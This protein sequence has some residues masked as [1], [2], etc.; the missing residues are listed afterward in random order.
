[1]FWVKPHSDIP[2]RHSGKVTEP[3]E[4]S[5]LFLTLFVLRRCNVSCTRQVIYWQQNKHLQDSTQVRRVISQY[6]PPHT[7]EAPL[8]KSA[9][10]TPVGFL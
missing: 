3:A 5:F 6:P 10:V 7:S 9:A 1:M 2:F 8:I 4:S